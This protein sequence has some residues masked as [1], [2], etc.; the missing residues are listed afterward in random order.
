NNVKSRHLLRGR[1]NHRV[2][3][4]LPESAD[5]NARE[6]AAS[7]FAGRHHAR[8]CGRYR[9]MRAVGAFLRR[10]AGCRFRQRR[11]Y[12]RC[13]AALRRAG[14]PS[15]M[16][17]LR[18][19]KAVRGGRG[20]PRLGAVPGR[21]RAAI[22]AIARIDLR[23]LR[24]WRSGARGLCAR[25]AQ[26]LSRPLARPWRRLSRLDDAAF[27]SPPRALERRSGARACRSRRRRAARRRSAPRF[28]RI[29]RALRRQAESL[30]DAPGGCASRKRQA[31]LGMGDGDRAARPVPA[32]LCAEARLPRRR[33]WLRAHRDR[34][35]RE[36]FEAREAPR[37]RS[38]GTRVVKDWAGGRILDTGASVTGADNLDP[39]YDVAL[40]EARID[41]LRPDPRFSF[42]RADLADASA[43]AAL[44]TRRFDAV[45]HLAAQPGVRYS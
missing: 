26:S 12:R 18:P 9:A 42:E 19:A 24:A 30:Y 38:R 1:E 23:A 5:R 27:R 43:C 14:G 34:R 36:L 45:V 39:Y 41:T 40:K 31:E 8:C 32:V 25:S 15:R 29:P 28:G 17:G 35:V 11:S 3:E 21:R 16:G 6:R 10:R 7:C 13:R 22:A 20:R 4:G 37:A 2:G 44:F 33:R